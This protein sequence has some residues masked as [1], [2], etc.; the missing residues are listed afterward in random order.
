MGEV[1]EELFGDERKTMQMPVLK[2]RV[3]G[4]LCDL[5]EQ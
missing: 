2:H 4:L 3:S 5:N 1:F